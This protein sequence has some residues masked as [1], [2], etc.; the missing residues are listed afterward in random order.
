[1]KYLEQADSDYL[2]EHLILSVLVIKCLSDV[3]W[4]YVVIK[5]CLPLIVRPLLTI[6]LPLPRYRAVPLLPAGNIFNSAPPGK[7][8]NSDAPLTPPLTIVVVMTGDVIFVDAPLTNSL[9]NWA[10]LVPFGRMA[11]F[12]VESCC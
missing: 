3:I 12:A 8:A 6:I 10:P 5:K 9:C 4:Y 7:R 11:V 1:M 2:C